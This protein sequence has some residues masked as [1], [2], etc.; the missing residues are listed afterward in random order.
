MGR[1][2]LKPASPFRHL[3]KKDPV[4]PIWREMLLGFCILKVKQVLHVP[5]AC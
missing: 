5:P 2:I 1:A 4:L 3:L